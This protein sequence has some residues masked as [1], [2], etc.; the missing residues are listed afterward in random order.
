M[1]TRLSILVCILYSVLCTPGSAQD[2]ARLSE[3]TI[4]GTARYIGMGGA[5]TA[6]GG[7]PAAA[8]DNMAGLGL[9]RRSEAMISLDVTHTAPRTN[10]FLPQASFVLSLPSVSEDSKIL[11]HNLL[12][13]YR[14][15][16]AYHRNLNTAGTKGASLGAL[17]IHA[18][19]EWDIPFCTDPINDEYSLSLRETGSVNEFDFGWAMNISNQW[20]VGVGINVQAYNL[21]AEAEYKELFGRRYNTNTTTLLYTGASFSA[22]AG[23]IYRPTGWL[24]LGFGIE[25]PSAGSLTTYSTGT[26]AAKTDSLRYSYAPDVRES[27]SH[28]HMPLHT[29]TSVAFQIGAY[30]MIALQHDYWH[31]SASEPMHS[32]RAGVE[33]IP[34]LGLYLNAG[35]AYESSFKREDISVPMQSTF[36]RQDTYFIRPKGTH[37]ASF[38][39]GYRGEK[40]IVQAAYQYRWNAMNVYAHENSAADYI[41]TDTHRVVLTLG[42]HN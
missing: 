7:D 1:R 10:V 12:F 34:V 2:Y 26:L 14:R 24:R 11:F 33:V 5:M 30:G 15:L 37:Y 23:L 17:I 8:H 20:Y 39:V 42:W 6:I 41:H 38:A 19:T 32:L 35:Y 16:H 18:D 28:F 3:R 29:S 27:D 4:M 21:S 36:E 40:M 31:I 9:Y 22:S 25:S 13:S